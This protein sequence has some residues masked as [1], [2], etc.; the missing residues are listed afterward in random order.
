MSMDSHVASSFVWA[1][2]NNHIPAEGDPQVVLEQALVSNDFRNGEIQRETLESM[3]R[4][5]DKA[6][7]Q[8][9]V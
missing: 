6:V 4:G 1:I 2:E 8:L 5:V 9:D 7:L 3:I